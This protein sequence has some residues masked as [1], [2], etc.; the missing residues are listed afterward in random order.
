MT[1]M[2][3]IIGLMIWLAVVFAAAGIGSIFTR[4]GLSQWYAALKKP[5]FNPPAWLFG[6]VWTMLYILMAVAAWLVWRDKGLHAAA[7][8]LALFAAQLALNAAWPA[9]FF[10]LKL[11]GAAFVELV[12]LWCAILATAVAFARVSPVAG[13]LMAP[14]ELWV[15]FAAILNFTIWRLNR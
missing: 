9:I 7:A 12:I 14:Y 5:S 10:G 13:A 11:P 2:Y 15:S 8:P 1:K 4:K 3:P 6:P